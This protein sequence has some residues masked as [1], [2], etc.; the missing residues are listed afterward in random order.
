MSGERFGLD[1]N[2]LY[3]AIDHAEPRRHRQAVGLIDRAAREHDCIVPLQAFCEFFS[4]ATRK[5]GMPFAEAAAQVADWQ[6]LFTTA[7]PGPASL[8]RALD[9]CLQHGLAFWDAL[10]WSVAKEAGVT[11]LLSED[12]QD[13]RELKGV[14]FRNPFGDQDPFRP[15]VRSSQP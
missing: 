14:V 5:G 7:Y 1:A 11:V 13:G 6:T 2:V 8:P 15:I 10:L 3:Y 12:L 9:T 4:A